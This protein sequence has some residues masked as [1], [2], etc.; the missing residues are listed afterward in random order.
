MD[1]KKATTDLRLLDILNQTL[2]D[3]IMRLSDLRITRKIHLES[4]LSSQIIVRELFRMAHQRRL[5]H[6]NFQMYF[7]SY[8]EI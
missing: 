1:K 4:A 3:G 2:L 5:S 6:S 8:S 7:S